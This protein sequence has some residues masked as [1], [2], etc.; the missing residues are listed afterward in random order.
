MLFVGMYVFSRV[1]IPL[2]EWYL[3][4]DIFGHMYQNDGGIQK[5]G[6]LK[7]DFEMN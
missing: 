3:S 2:T 1:L 5:S 6:V 7:P 4:L